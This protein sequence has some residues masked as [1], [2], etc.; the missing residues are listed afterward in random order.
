MRTCGISPVKRSSPDVLPWLIA[1][2]DKVLHHGM[3]ILCRFKPWH[4][5][6]KVLYGAGVA[7]PWHIGLHTFCVAILVSD[8]VVTKPVEIR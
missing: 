3:E 6:V 4:G 5:R 1:K 2:L 7:K 8:A